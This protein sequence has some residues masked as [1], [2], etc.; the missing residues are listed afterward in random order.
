MEKLDRLGWAAGI[1]ITSF[2]VSAGIR[3]NDPAALDRVLPAL[4]P[5]WR[6][7]ETDTVDTIFSLYFAGPPARP[8]VKNYHLLY[9]DHVRLA[10]V[11]E[12]EQVF[13]SLE[14]WLEFF[15]A[16][17]AREMIFLHAGVVGWRGGAV[18]FPGRSFSGKSTLVHE[19]VRAGAAYYSDEF[20]VLDRKGLVH[21]YPRPIALRSSP[22]ERP[23]KISPAADCDF[24]ALEPLPVTKV[25]VTKYREGARWRPKSVGAGQGA[26]ELIANTV[27]ARQKP[28]LMVEVFRNALSGATFLI[29]KRGEA[30]QMVNS[31]L[32]GS[33]PDR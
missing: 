27:V 28:E 3:T 18:L 25:I 5:V 7:A 4:P 2:G 24:R 16:S 32:D 30:S 22:R 15:L 17:N 6:S 26:L 12:E 14:R 23:V 20:A 29:G 8:N 31:V 21:P 13:S 10:R 19:L 33:S 1:A 11:T 9:G